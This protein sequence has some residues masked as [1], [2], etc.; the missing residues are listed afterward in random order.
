M[1]EFRI[2]EVNVDKT[3]ARAQK[4][5]Q[6]GQKQGLSGGFKVSI[7]ER[8]EQINGVD[9]QYQVLVIEGEPLKYQGWEFIGVAEFVEEQIILH[10][11]SEENPIQISDVRKGY[12]DHCQKVRNR[13][14]VIFVKNEEGKLSQVG[15]SCVKDFIGWTFYASALVTEEDF[16]EE[17]G[18][19]QFGGISAISTEAIIA[20]AIKAVG[21]LGYV[22]SSEGISTKDLVWGV[23]KNIHQYNEIWAKHQIGEAGQAEYEKARQLIEWGKNFEGDSSYA[24][25]VRSVCQLGFQKDSTVGIAVSI[26]KAESNQREKEIVEKVEFKKEQ[27]AETGSKVEVE[28][29]VAGSNTFETQYGWTTLF[30][31]VNEGGY[32]FKWFSSNGGNVEIGDKVKIKGTVKGSDEYKDVFSTVL[33]RCKFV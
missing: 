15:S 9:C 3:L 17:F 13:G 24:Q 33:T 19:Y 18:G 2:S 20:H 7:Q 23:L 14:K 22:K 26:V 31:F 25:N 29:T 16:A 27:F 5:A 28:V 10:G 8:V 30:T 12:C 11:F 32:Q 21:K 1:R 4:I 6:R